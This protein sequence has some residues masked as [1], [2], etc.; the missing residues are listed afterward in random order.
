[1][2]LAMRFKDAECY[3]NSDHIITKIGVHC[4]D[5]DGLVID[6]KGYTPMERDYGDPWMVAHYNI[7]SKNEK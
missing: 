4:Y 6:K 2:L 7:L 5:W 3:Y 1:M